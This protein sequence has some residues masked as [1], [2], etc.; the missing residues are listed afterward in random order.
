MA[1]YWRGRTNEALDK[2][3]AVVED[4]SVAIASGSLPPDLYI[5]ALFSR[6]LA[7]LDRSLPSRPIG[8][9]LTEAQ[10]RDTS[11]AEADF[12]SIVELRNTTTA[13]VQR[14]RARYRIGKDADAER[15]LRSAYRRSSDSGRQEDRST[16][17][18]A[19][20]FQGLLDLRRA[21]REHSVTSASMAEESF[22]LSLR[23]NPDLSRSKAMR[24]LA[25]IG[26]GYFPAGIRQLED[27]MNGLSSDDPQR[28]VGTSYLEEARKAFAALPVQGLVLKGDRIEGPEGTG[29]ELLATCVVHGR[30]GVPCR[31]VLRV[32]DSGGSPYLYR[33]RPLR[34]QNP[35]YRTP[36]GNLAVVE[37][38]SRRKT[39]TAW[40]TCASTSRTRRPIRSTGSS[41]TSSR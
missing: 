16:A 41:A 4:L 35:K 8:I 33:W 28:A 36:E 7:L 2:L 34:A 6:G 38:S 18:D 27:L 29:A 40:T 26:M 30:K 23:A 9:E 10:R 5:E 3:D 19:T 14:G 15:D 22:D 39:P 25:E 13:L 31:V 37:A 20:Y 24:A 1:R 21:R 12:S 17:S 11:T 32:F